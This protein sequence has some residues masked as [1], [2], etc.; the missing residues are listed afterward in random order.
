MIR[1]E[2]CGPDVARIVGEFE[3]SMVPEASAE[4]EF[5]L[6]LHHEDTLS[7]RKKFSSD[8]ITLCNGMPINPFQQPKL[9]SINNSHIIPD[10]AYNTLKKMEDIGEQ[11]SYQ[12]FQG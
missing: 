6:H 12:N 9:M 1:W 7:F 4:N 3:E 5:V 8:V 11:R 2:T 10:V